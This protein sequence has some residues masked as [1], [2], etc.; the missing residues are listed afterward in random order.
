MKDYANIIYLT[1]HHSGKGGIAN[2]SRILT[3][4]LEK[5]KVKIFFSYYPDYF[6]LKYFFIY[7]RFFIIIR[8]Y[9]IIHLNTPFSGKSIFRDLPY[10]LISLI[11]KKRLIVNFRGGTSEFYNKVKKSKVLNLLMRKTYFKSDKIIV[12]GNQIKIDYG[13]IS[14]IPSHKFC[15][16]WNP[17]EELYLNQVPKQIDTNKKSIKLL[18]LSRINLKKGCEIALET[19]RLLMIKYPNY[20]FE[21]NI[22]G[23]GP[24]LEKI[25][26]ITNEKNINNV[27][28]HGDVRGKEKI[29]QY[30]KNDIF[31]FPTYYGEG[32]PGTILEAMAFG[33]PVISRPVA[34]ISDWIKNNQNGFL[35]DSKSPEDFVELVE[36]LL[37]NPFL[38]N[39]VSQNNIDTANKYFSPQIV[40]E[41]IIYIYDSIRIK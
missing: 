15:V 16:I 9:S 26:S 25:R 24:L 40:T 38:Y 27:F 8:K 34:G 5:Y 3:P 13:K 29:K 28:F 31:L 35:T 39:T 10:I 4:Y 17:I 12:L 6:P 30:L 14:K 18:F 11:F 7:L 22:C 20:F 19:F 23:D 36:K 37:F 41:K 32:L 2:V 21:L 33:L 1:S